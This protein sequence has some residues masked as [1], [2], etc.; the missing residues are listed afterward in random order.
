MEIERAL[1]RRMGVEIVLPEIAWKDHLAALGAGTSDIAAGATASEA[2]SA[3]AYF[4]KPY[5][6]ETDVLVLPTGASG[7]YPFTTIPE[8]L[9]TFVR[10]KFRLGVVAGFVYAD[11]RVNAFIRIP[12]TGSRSSRSQPIPITSEICWV[13]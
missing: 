6:T 5:R 4:S 11:E 9:D 1:A 3:Y 12:R 13:A 2:R 10:E 8:M 7:R